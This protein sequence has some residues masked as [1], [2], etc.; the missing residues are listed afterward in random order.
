MSRRRRPG[1]FGEGWQ[2]GGGCRGGCR[3]WAGVALLHATALMPKT[4]LLTLRPPYQLSNPPAAT[5]W[6]QV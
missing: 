4:T 6:A 3:G 1:P 5:A 2:A